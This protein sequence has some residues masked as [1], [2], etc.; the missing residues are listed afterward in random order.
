GDFDGDGRVD[1]F[2][3][4]DVSENFLF[5]NLGNGK[6]EEIAMD[7]GVA[8]SGNGDEQ[9]SMGVD[10]GDY[11]LDGNPDI[12]VT[13]YQKQLNALYR[14]DGPI[15]FSDL[16]TK[17]GLGDT[18]LPLVSWGTGFAD[19][20]SDGWPD[21]FI[22][23]GHLEDR[24]KEYD[25]S[26]TYLQENQI[27]RNRSGRFQDVS[28]SSGPAFSEKKS[29]RG[30][31][32]GDVDGDG[33]IDVV[34]NNSRGSVSLLINETKTTNSWVTLDL[35]GRV[36]RFAIGAKAAVHSGGKIYRAEVRSGGSYVSQN[37]LRLHFGLGTATSIDKVTVR[38]SS[39]KTSEH[40]GLALGRVHRLD[41]PN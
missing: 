8:L 10:S 34:V 21:L 11:D 14:S 17:H 24:I 19:F 31:A 36:N 37:D 4:N 7:Q 41:E 9:G 12:V 26:S 3:A 18:C 35:R 32:F 33:D 39:G 6:F 38:W 5:K 13:N 30:A 1:I 27:F 22:A 20:D 25:D 16:A 29:S 15:G 28:V 2:V 40:P 23:N